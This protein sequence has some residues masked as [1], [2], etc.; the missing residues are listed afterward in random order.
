MNLLGNVQFKYQMNLVL[1]PSSPTQ[2]VIS[3]NNLFVFP[4]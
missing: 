1:C 4:F 3:I 2:N